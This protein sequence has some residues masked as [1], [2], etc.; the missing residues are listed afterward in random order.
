M[1]EYRI[2][3]NGE[4][5]RIQKEADN[6]EWVFIDGRLGRWNGR[7]YPLEF[8]DIVKAR[9]KIEEFKKHDE[10][11]AQQYTWEVVE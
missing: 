11:F 7:G 6:G 8:S 3:T 1:K 9:E 4:V 10:E 2:V 5:F